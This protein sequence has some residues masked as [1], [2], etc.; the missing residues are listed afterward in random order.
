MGEKETDEM[1]ENGGLKTK[2][3]QNREMSQ[4]E[5]ERSEE[6]VREES[7]KD[8]REETVHIPKLVRTQSHH[9]LTAT[10]SCDVS[11][12]LPNTSTTSDEETDHGSPETEYPKPSSN[13]QK[14]Q[15]RLARQKQ[16]EELHAREAALARE[17]RLMRRRGLLTT[18]PKKADE[19]RVMWK[20]EEDLV[21]VFQ[22]S[23]CSSSR[24]STL[25]PEDIPELNEN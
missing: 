23:P 17:E 20:E 16:L 2:V 15:R 10:F 1:R 21:E 12:E 7:D 8:D 24:G 19:R 3:Y 6:K 22:Y 25:E 5:Q 11:A 14:M 13:Y 9:Y 18:P 4:E